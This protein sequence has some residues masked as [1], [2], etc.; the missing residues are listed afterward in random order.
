MGFKKYKWHKV[1]ADTA[2][3]SRLS[4]NGES[5]IEVDAD[6]QKVCLGRFK[7]EW[8]GFAHVCPHAGA[9]MTEGYING[10]CQVVCPVHQLKFDLKNGRDINGEGYNLKM[11]PIELRRDGVFVGLPEGGL[12][13]WF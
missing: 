6:G 9:P 11:Y 7:E 13:K 1:A 5:I 8:Y 2:E 3:L 4:R 10:S 12:F